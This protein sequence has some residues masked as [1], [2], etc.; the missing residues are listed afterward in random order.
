MSQKSKN[1][2]PQEELNELKLQNAFRLIK[3]ERYAAARHVLREL[4]E[5]PKALKMLAFIE[6]KSEKRKSKSA[7]SAWG[8]FIVL[9]VVFVVGGIILGARFYEDFMSQFTLDELALGASGDDFG[10][11][12]ALINYCSIATNYQ[13]NKCLQWPIELM[14]EYPEAFEA[15][16]A[17]YEETVVLEDGHVEGIRRCLGGYNV[18]APY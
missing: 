2:A 12:S 17:P 3:Q 9:F 15:C 10:A 1:Q 14:S 18:P 4:P 16:F 11:V 8:L 7:I 13:R 5:H 6:G